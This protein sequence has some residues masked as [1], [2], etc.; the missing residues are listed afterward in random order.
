[1][2]STWQSRPG[3]GSVGKP[4]F[5]NQPAAPVVQ[6][7]QEIVPATQLEQH[8]ALV[9]DVRG[10]NVARV[11]A[12]FALAIDREVFLVRFVDG[13]LGCVGIVLG[14]DRI[15]RPSHKA[16]TRRSISCSSR[17]SPYQRRLIPIIVSPMKP[18][19]N[20]KTGG[21]ANTAV[22]GI[23]R[24]LRG[25]GQGDGAAPGRIAAPRRYGRPAGT[26]VAR[27]TGAPGRH[28]GQALRSEHPGG[29]GRN[30]RRA[31]RGSAG[32]G[33]G[34]RGRRIDGHGRCRGNRRGAGCRRATGRS[35]RFCPK[36]GAR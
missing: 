34:R 32:G 12:A 14:E 17:R 9:E 20:S 24:A 11:D 15:S 8:G 25:G 27:R 6:V 31:G 13:A 29:T 4:L 21:V 3:V 30:H 33:A 16:Q 28:P 36:S 10:P 1:M 18:D 22:T 7:V 35:R 23:V 2:V 26:R 5:S 19:R